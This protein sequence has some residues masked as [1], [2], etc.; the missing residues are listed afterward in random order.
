MKTKKDFEAAA[1]HVR[2]LPMTERKGK[3]LLY[4]REFASENKK[5]D[6]ERFFAACMVEIPTAHVNM[7]IKSL[8][9]QII[10]N[11]K[12]ML[13]PHL[14]D[15]SYVDDAE[16]GKRLKVFAVVTEDFTVNVMDN[17][18]SITRKLRPKNITLGRLQGQLYHF[19]FNDEG[20]KVFYREGVIDHNGF[21]AALHEF[22]S[23][24]LED[25]ILIE[26]WMTKHLQREVELRKEY[27]TQ[28]K[29]NLTKA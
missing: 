9:R 21:G 25:L 19:H 7:N 5:F 23:F 4:A 6:T 26:Q 22:D 2:A 28:R 24:C 11:L 27:D 29:K 18:F 14:W 8:K 17:P 3:A 12:K 15:S 16:E 20:I 1:V 10:K 13:A